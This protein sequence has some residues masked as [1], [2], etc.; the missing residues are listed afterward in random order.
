MDLADVSACTASGNGLDGRGFC[1]ASAKD[2]RVGV[3]ESS[4]VGKGFEGSCDKDTALD[5]GV[6]DDGVVVEVVAVPWSLA[7]ASSVLGSA[8][9]RVLTG[10]NVEVMVMEYAITMKS[11][12]VGQVGSTGW[13]PTCR[14]MRVLKYRPARR[15]VNG[16]SVVRERESGKKKKK[17]K[18]VGSD[19]DHGA[20]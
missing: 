5:R 7:V 18:S 20:C 14:W 19:T 17:K 9:S 12:R 13:M 11:Y 2:A 15:L 3:V 8:A 16:G 6:E 1:E 10:L 4:V